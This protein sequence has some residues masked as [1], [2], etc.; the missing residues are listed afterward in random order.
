MSWDRSRSNMGQRWPGIRQKVLRNSGGI[1]GLCGEDG[2]VEVDH[3]IPRHLGG[4][5][6]PGNLMAVCR[7]CH[8]YKSSAEGHAAQARK[9]KLRKRPA[10]KHPGRLYD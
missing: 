9:R 1:C 10:D 7:K 2:A 8:G 6:D 3:I 4:S 5:S